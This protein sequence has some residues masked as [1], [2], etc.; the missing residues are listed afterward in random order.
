MPLNATTAGAAVHLPTGLRMRPWTE[1]DF[2]PAAHLISHAYTGHLDSRINDQYQTIAGSLRFLHNI[3]RFP[4]CGLFDAA[5]SRVL[6]A[7]A[8]GEMAGILLCSRVQEQV[9]H[10][11]QVCVAPRWRRRGLGALLLRD[12]AAHLR[13]RG[14]HSLTLTVTQANYDAVR[15]Y[16]H[17]GFVRIHS[18]DAML[19]VRQAGTFS[20][21]TA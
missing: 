7:E 4:G 17:L 20:E 19:W 13:R 15:L 10:V 9:G 5:A 21:A 11:T 16:E 3:V 2:T 1:E 14:F 12:C 18:F 6:V 8:T